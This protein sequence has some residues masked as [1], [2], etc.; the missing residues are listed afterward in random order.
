[1]VKNLDSLYQPGRRVGYWLKVKPVMETLDLV[2]TSADWGEGRRARWLGSFGLSVRDPDSGKYLECGK[3]G[4]GFKEK[5]E[6]EDDVTLDE[7]TKLLKPHITHEKGRRV[8]IEPKA[9][10]EVAYEEIQASPT[11]ESGYALRFP[12]LVRIRYERG[13][14]EADTA[15]R[16]K[17]LYKSQK[18][19]RVGS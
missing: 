18:G 19:K 12:R 7:M 8:E 9:V 11:Y 16:L 1:M 5:K 6:D 17:L 2:V 14:R 4:T 15:Q 10:L 13:A 3:L